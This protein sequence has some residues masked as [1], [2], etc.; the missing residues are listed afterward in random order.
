MKTKKRIKQ[1]KK[2]ITEVSNYV[3]ELESSIMV[4]TDEA[5]KEKLQ[6][7]IQDIINESNTIEESEHYTATLKKAVVAVNEF[8]EP[9]IRVDKAL[10][11]AW[12]G[13]SPEANEMLEKRVADLEE[14]VAHLNEFGLNQT[15]DPNTLNIFGPGSQAGRRYKILKEGLEVRLDELQSENQ[16]VWK[17]VTK[18][19]KN[20]QRLSN[21]LVQNGL[22]SNA[23]DVEVKVNEKVN[24]LEDE[25]KKLKN[26]LRSEGI[27]Y[28]HI[29]KDG[30]GD[31]DIFGN[32]NKKQL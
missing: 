27:T 7:V 22:S 10:K 20:N 14:M 4:M 2:Q 8:S 25:N 21:I 29:N 9:K 5:E 18:L 3:L 28:S 32:V 26:L 23:T 31:Y 30:D 24:E 17:R 13:Y 6:P 15:P 1:L 11:S 19:N 16:R 12:P